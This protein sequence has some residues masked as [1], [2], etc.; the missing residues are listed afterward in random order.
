[1]R[2]PVLCGLWKVEEVQK[3]RSWCFVLWGMSMGFRGREDGDG[4]WSLEFGELFGG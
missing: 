4:L 2:N 3:R 1:V